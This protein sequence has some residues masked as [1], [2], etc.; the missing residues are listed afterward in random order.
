ML[1]DDC[2]HYQLTGAQHRVSLTLKKALEPF[3]LTPVQFGVLSCLWQ[4]NMHNPKEI[5]EFIGVENST[6]SGILDRME[7]KGLLQRS[8][9]VNDRRFIRIDLTDVSK[10]LEGPVLKAVDGFN[11]E[12]LSPFS[13]AEQKQLKKILRIISAAE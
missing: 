1:I 2:I 4:K 11:K 7:K 12:I 5:A 13:T 10:E 9:D 3:D 8:I 6:I